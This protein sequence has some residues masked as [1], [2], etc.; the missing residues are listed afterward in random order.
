MHDQPNNP[1]AA[2][3]L[4]KKI[5]KVDIAMMTTMTPEGHFRT[6][7]MYTTEVDSSGI[8]WFFTSDQ[9]EK[10]RE[11]QQNPQ[12]SLGYA[13]PDDNTYVS[14]SGTAELVKDQAKMHD[15]YNP[16]LKAWFPDGL[17][18]PDI[19]LLRVTIDSAEYWD[20]TSNAML[21]LYGIAKAAITGKPPE[22]NNEKL[23]IR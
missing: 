10:V 4:H 6:R 22:T 7:P 14:A 5:E 23:D 20:V 12:I 17:D 11:I 18:S 8:V 1:D 13:D 9:S 2:I 21:H 15:L 16:A 3:K 19:S